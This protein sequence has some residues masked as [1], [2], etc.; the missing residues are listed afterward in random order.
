M[1]ENQLG[2]YHSRVIFL[3]IFLLQQGADTKATQEAIIENRRFQRGLEISF[4]IT[5]A[6]S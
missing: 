2:L 6:M 4:K 1:T 5:I 3:K